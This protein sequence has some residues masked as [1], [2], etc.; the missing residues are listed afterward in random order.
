M[1]NNKNSYL[2]TDDNTII[3][4]KCIRWVKKMSE[5]LEVCS[6]STGCSIKTGGTHKICKLNS[7]YSYNKLNQFFE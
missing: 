4:E 3:N 5:C 1:E 6:K 2:K 7:P